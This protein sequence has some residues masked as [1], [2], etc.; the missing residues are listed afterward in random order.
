MG[1]E[2]V[3]G[4]MGVLAPVWEHHEWSCSRLLLLPKGRTMNDPESRWIPQPSNRNRDNSVS[5]VHRKY[6]LHSTLAQP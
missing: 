4:I 5:A 3:G 6:G 1:A 2:I